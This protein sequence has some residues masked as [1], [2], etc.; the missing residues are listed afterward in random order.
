MAAFASR[1]LVS[2]DAAETPY[3]GYE[4]N[5]IVWLPT[6]ICF[7]P[8]HRRKGRPLY[9]PLGGRLHGPARTEPWRPRARPCSNGWESTGADVF[10]ITTAPRHHQLAASGLPTAADILLQKAYSDMKQTIYPYTEGRAYKSTYRWGGAG[11]SNRWES[12]QYGAD[13]VSGQK[14]VSCITMHCSAAL[15]TREYPY[16]CGHPAAEGLPGHLLDI[17]DSLLLSSILCV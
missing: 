4:D 8:L 16:S 6:G 14:R 5:T 9:L 1:R 11:I 7:R 12:L 10:C 17:C 3:C 15:S 2:L 13:V